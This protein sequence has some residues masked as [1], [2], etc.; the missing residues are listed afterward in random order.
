MKPNHKVT[1]GEIEAQRL[2]YEA[3]KSGSRGTRQTRSSSN[4]PKRKPTKKSKKRQVIR[5]HDFFLIAKRVVDSD[6]EGNDASKNEDAKQEKA[7]KK[8]RAS[9]L[10]K[11]AVLSSELVIPYFNYQV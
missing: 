11:P 6:D 4:P 1:R 7:P 3:F 8:K 10:T 2:L 9:G 5:I